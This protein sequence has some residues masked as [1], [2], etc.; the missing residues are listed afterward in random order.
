ML[1]S[2]VRAKILEDHRRLRGELGR[3]EATAID[4]EIGEADAALLRELGESF[5]EQLAAHM[6]W[7]DQNLAPALR[8]ADA[9]GEE[10]ERRLVTEHAE[11]RAQMR[12]LLD[13]LHETQRDARQLAVDLLELVEWLRR[14]MEHEERETLDPDVLRDDVVAIDASD[15]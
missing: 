9:W 5:L 2:E 15:G 12:S 14:D 13:R 10:R 1:P 3:L 11:Q 4:G 8:D 7:E 6:R